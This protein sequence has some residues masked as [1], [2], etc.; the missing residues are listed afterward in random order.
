MTLLVRV[1]VFDHLRDA[2]R[3]GR[4]GNC[5]VRENSRGNLIST[6]ADSAGAFEYRFADNITDGQ[7]NVTNDQAGNDSECGIKNE[8]NERAAYAKQKASNQGCMSVFGRLGFDAV[9]TA[10]ARKNTVD[11]VIASTERLVAGLATLR[12]GFAGVFGRSELWS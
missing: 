10:L 5:G 11:A 8:A 2:N 9:N 1:P 12:A 4:H 7:G 3:Y 6:S